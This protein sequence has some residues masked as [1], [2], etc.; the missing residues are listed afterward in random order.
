MPTN[1]DCKTNDKTSVYIQYECKV[2]DE[3]LS[4]KKMAATLSGVVACFSVLFF[5]AWLWYAKRN[6]QLIKWQY[7]LENVTASDYT[8]EIKLS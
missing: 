5:I 4:N 2:T 3:R 1:G 6:L 7:D 8:L